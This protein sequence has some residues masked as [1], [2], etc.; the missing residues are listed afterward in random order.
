MDGFHRRS[1][2]KISS[3]SPFRTTWAAQKSRGEGFLGTWAACTIT[4]GNLPDDLD[5]VKILRGRLPQGL[6]LLHHRARKASWRLWS[7]QNVERK[8]SCALGAT[9]PRRKGLRSTGF[10]RGTSRSEAFLDPYCERHMSL[11][12]LP[13]P[14]LRAAQVARKPSWIDVAS[15][16]CHSEA[17][18]ALCCERHM[19][20]GNLPCRSLSVAQDDRKPSLRQWPSNAAFGNSRRAPS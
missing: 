6:G 7:A 5:H 11:G 18:L 17:F 13:G 1:P 12:S 4:P 10:F 14:M 20:P 9:A 8:P 3:Y 19:S 15:G 16:I 2:G